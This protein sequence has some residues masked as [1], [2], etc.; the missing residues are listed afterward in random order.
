[1]L[2]LCGFFEF[3]I[4]IHTHYQ[5]LPHNVGLLS[6]ILRPRVSCSHTQLKLSFTTQANVGPNSY[7][8]STKVM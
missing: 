2:V 4:Y 3:Y 6:M 7:I 1:M 8:H 5:T